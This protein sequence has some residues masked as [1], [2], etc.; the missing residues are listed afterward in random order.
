MKAITVKFHGWTNTKSAR[1][2]AR[3][4]DGNKFEHIDSSLDAAK[5]L[6]KKMNWHGTLA[7]GMTQQGEVF[8]FVRKEDL[9][10]V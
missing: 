3:D 7:S 6:C 1:Y 2:V 9:F 5:G 10:H 8:V 4:L